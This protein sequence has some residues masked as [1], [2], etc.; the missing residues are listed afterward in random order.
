VYWIEE[1]EILKEEMG[2]EAYITEKLLKMSEDALLIKLAD[3]VYNSY[4]QPGEKALNRMYK[5]V[6]ELLLKRELNDKCRELANLVIL[7]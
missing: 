1:Y 3:M 2:K 6:C 4:D 7:A 5:N